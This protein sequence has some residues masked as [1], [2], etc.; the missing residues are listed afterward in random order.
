MFLQK[1]TGKHVAQVVCGG[2]HTAAITV[3]GELFTWG[4]GEHG[5]LGHGDKV[6]KTVPWLVTFLSKM[7]LVRLIKIFFFFFFFLFVSQYQTVLLT[8]IE[9]IHTLFSCMVRY[10]L[11]VAGVI[12]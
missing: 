5:Q 11:H 12:Q 3:D 8:F 6:N 1:Q 2:F 7:N 4:G 9:N 10:K